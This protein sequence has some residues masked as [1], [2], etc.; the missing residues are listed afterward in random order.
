M[1]SNLCTV[2][3]IHFYGLGDI[4]FYGPNFLFIF[5]VKPTGGEGY[6][7]H[8]I[9]SLAPQAS[10]VLFRLSLMSSKRLS[11]HDR[12]EIFRLKA[13]GKSNA[14]LANIFKVTEGGIRYVLNTYQPGNTAGKHK[15]GS[16]KMTPRCDL[17]VFV[18]KSTL[19]SCVDLGT[20]GCFFD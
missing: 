8:A 17:C 5:F 14:L 16:S 9:A 15:G 18:C 6:E 19:F 2:G 3:D 20:N 12:E 11:P 10:P 4:D 13:E 1:A 7:R